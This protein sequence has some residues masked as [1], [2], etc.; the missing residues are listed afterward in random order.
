[1]QRAQTCSETLC[2]QR[3]RNNMKQ[4]PGKT[5]TQNKGIVGKSSPSVNGITKNSIGAAVPQRKPNKFMSGKE[6]LGKAMK[7]MQKHG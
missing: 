7:G 3:K 1:M 4:T 6:L 2:A 5:P